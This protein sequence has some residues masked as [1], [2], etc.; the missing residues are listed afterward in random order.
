MQQRFS[1]VPHTGNGS[2]LA[3]PAF[4]LGGSQGFP[5]Q[6]DQQHLM[7]RGQGSTECRTKRQ[8]T[9]PPSASVILSHPH[10]LSQSVTKCCSYETCWS[11]PARPVALSPPA[12]AP[13]I[14][15]LPERFPGSSHFPSLEATPHGSNATKTAF[16]C[17]LCS[18]VDGTPYGL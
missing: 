7:W 4:P 6:E 11:L 12:D 5:P 15:L 14:W 2:F 8:V 17:P 18:E 1:G 13:T 16:L 3:H 10:L 9:G